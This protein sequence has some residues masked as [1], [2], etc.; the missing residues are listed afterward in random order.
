MPA[1]W[2]DS[3]AFN[4]YSLTKGHTH[5]GGPVVNVVGRDHPLGSLSD[6]LLP[7]IFVKLTSEFLSASSPPPVI[8]RVILVH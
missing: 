6:F 2:L 4:V 8:L 3:M 1:R 5:L 7:V